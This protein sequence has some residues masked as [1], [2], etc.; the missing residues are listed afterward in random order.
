MI[1]GIAQGNAQ[2]WGP[3][4]MPVNKALCPAAGT[5]PGDVVEVAME[6]DEEPRTVDDPPGR[7]KELAKKQVSAGARGRARL[8][9][10]EGNRE[11]DP[12]REAGRDER[13]AA[14]KGDAGSED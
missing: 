13:T 7:V 6:R 14:S 12:G 3:P 10:A 8:H 5:K 4:L 11:F 9:P 2:V 1:L